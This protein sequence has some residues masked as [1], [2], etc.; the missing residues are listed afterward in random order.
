M[1]YLRRKLWEGVNPVISTSRQPVSRV[2]IIESDYA[3]RRVKYTEEDEVNMCKFLAIAAPDPAAGG[4]LG[5]GIWNFLMSFQTV[6]NLCYHLHSLLI[7]CQNPDYAW[8]KRHTA[9]SWQEHYKKNKPRLDPLIADEVARKPPPANGKGLYY[10]SRNV[11]KRNQLLEK[12]VDLDDDEEWEVRV[13]ESS[14]EEVDMSGL[15]RE[16][17]EELV[18][19]RKPSTNRNMS[20]DISSAEQPRYARHVHSILFAKQTEVPSRSTE[21]RPGDDRED[22]SSDTEELLEI[23][24][25]FE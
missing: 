14:H 5:P 23:P 11:T 17:V 9:Q 6:C 20:D 16:E 18:T 22:E 12:M 2:F 21:K 13:A 24:P 1:R 7:S 3:I 8:V 15:E 10:L 4:R 19:P 25:D